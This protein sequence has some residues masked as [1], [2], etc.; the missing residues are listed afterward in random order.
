M[1]G[2]VLDDATNIRHMWNIS[3]DDILKIFFNCGLLPMWHVLVYSDQ[4]I[5]ESGN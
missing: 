1:I 3:D 4:L 2:Y 5:F